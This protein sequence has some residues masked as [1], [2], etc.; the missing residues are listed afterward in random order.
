MVQ[1]SGARLPWLEVLGFRVLGLG[2]QTPRFMIHGLRLWFWVRVR[3][4]WPR[5]WE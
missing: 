2:V 5:G 1:G 3:V 4:V